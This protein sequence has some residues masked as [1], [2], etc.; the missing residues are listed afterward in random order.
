[1]SLDRALSV[2]GL[3][4]S[5]PGFLIV[6]LADDDAAVAALTL[7]LGLLTL[8]A[9]AAVY[10]FTNLPEFSLR[11]VA[12]ALD[13]RDEAGRRATLAKSYRILPNYGHLDRMVHRNIAADGS[14]RNICW[15]GAPVPEGN[16]REV[17]GQYEVTIGFGAP[18][19]RWA[20]FP[21]RLSYEVV[22]SFPG[23]VEAL[24]YVVDFPTRVLEIRVDF[25]PGRL[26]RE[27][28]AVRSS[29]GRRPLRPPRV[30]PDGRTLELKVRRPMRGAEYSIYWSW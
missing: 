20:E 27:P 24:H 11:S 16:V 9:A 10:Y 12:V 6:V 17:L 25:P 21:G 14:V 28:R 23:R 13:I 2:I 3:L 30:S 26:P 4:L 7:L 1:M 8:A 22:D 18:L 5:L 15:N 29:G 19:P